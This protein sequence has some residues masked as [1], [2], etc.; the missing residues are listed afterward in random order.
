VPEATNVPVVGLKVKT[1]GGPPVVTSKSSMT[2]DAGFTSPENVTAGGADKV[3]AVVEP[4]KVICHVDDA[5]A[6][7]VLR[8][9]LCAAGAPVVVAVIVAVTP[10]GNVDPVTRDNAPETPFDAGTTTLFVLLGETAVEA[11]AGAGVGLGLGATVTIGALELG[12]GPDDPPPPP[13]PAVTPAMSKMIPIRLEARAL[14][15]T[16]STSRLSKN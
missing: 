12:A 5:A 10:L 14:T 8:R 16:L 15:D 7:S 4:V 1:S 6:A 9:V 2:N 3:V 11:V 13:Q